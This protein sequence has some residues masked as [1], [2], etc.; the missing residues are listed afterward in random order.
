MDKI[1][2]LVADASV[3]RKVLRCPYSCSR[4]RRIASRAVKCVS[5][6]SADIQVRARRYLFS[7]ESSAF[8]FSPSLYVVTKVIVHA[9]SSSPRAFTSLL[10][11]KPETSKQTARHVCRRRDHKTY[12]DEDDMACPSESP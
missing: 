9:S 2:V 8:R 3:G 6:S 10:A 5:G 12:S 1:D 11:I 7:V 4:V